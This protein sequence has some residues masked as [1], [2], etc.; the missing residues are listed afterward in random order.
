MVTKSKLFSGYT[1]PHSVSKQR[2][3]LSGNRFTIITSR[4][5]DVS[6]VIATI[7]LEQTEKLFLCVLA[8]EQVC[9][10]QKTLWFHL[11]FYRPYKSIDCGSNQKRNWCVTI[12]GKNIM[13][14]NPRIFSKKVMTFI[15]DMLVTERGLVNFLSNECLKRNINIYHGVIRFSK[16]TESWYPTRNKWI[17]ETC[18]PELLCKQQGYYTIWLRNKAIQKLNSQYG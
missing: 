1:V 15:T 8:T 10:N 12:I 14:I 16:R 18:W 4:Y 17:K 13:D 5:K 7:A 3:S 9:V 2:L 11:I 6:I